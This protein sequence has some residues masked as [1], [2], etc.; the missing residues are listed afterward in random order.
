MFGLPL[1]VRCMP[2]ATRRLPILVVWQVGLEAM[3][4]GVET[5]PSLNVIWLD[6]PPPREPGEQVMT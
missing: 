6:E 4:T 3:L 5:M 1:M 2:P